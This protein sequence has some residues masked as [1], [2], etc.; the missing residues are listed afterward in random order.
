MR[1]GVRPG[2]GYLR[3]VASHLLDHG[4]FAGVPATTVVE[5][6]HPAFHYPVRV[7]DGGKRDAINVRACVRAVCAVAR[8]RSEQ[9]GS[10]G[11]LTLDPSIFTHTHSPGGVPAAGA[12]RGAS[13]WA[14]SRSM[15]GTTSW[16][17]T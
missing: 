13:R 17:R 11:R 8:Q 5:A 4:N 1:P 3:E 7:W 12:G 15:C 10:I 16:W 6:R 14:P 2:E 9:A